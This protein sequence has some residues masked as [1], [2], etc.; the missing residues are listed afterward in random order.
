MYLKKWAM[1]GLVVVMMVCG[2]PAYSGQQ[3]SNITEFVN[4]Y[5]CPG[6][7]HMNETEPKD[8][9]HLIVV[10]NPPGLEAYYGTD[11]LGRTPIDLYVPNY[12]I[13]TLEEMFHVTVLNPITEQAVGQSPPEAHYGGKLYVYTFGTFSPALSPIQSHPY[14]Y[15]SCLRGWNVQHTLAAAKRKETRLVVE[16][17][18]PGAVVFINGIVIGQTPLHTF[19]HSLPA[20]G[21]EK[22]VMSE[23]S[24]PTGQDINGIKDKTVEEGLMPVIGS[25]IY[26]YKDLRP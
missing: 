26:V 19:I 21:E 7:L 13:N 1:A 22:E 18:P 6:G 12:N 14:K 16:T 3:K 8:Y 23:I 10:S 11:Y 25:T 4:K 5:G 17:T 20:Y 24:W 15:G 2:G 9:V